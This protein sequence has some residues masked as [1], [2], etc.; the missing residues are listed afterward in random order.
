VDIFDAAAPA[1][2]LRL[3]AIALGIGAVVLL[4]SLYYLF[5]VF[6]S[7]RAADAAD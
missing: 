2:T 3:L 4:P 1:V 5:H 7:R 6:K